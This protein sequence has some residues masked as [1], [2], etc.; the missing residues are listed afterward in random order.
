[1]I[2]MKIVGTLII[3]LSKIATAIDRLIAYLYKRLS[4]IHALETA[5]INMKIA[6][7]KPEPEEVKIDKECLN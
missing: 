5:N 1:M 2:R 4:I 6:A 3:I 7:L